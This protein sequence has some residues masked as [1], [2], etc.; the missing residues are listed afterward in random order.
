MALRLRSANNC[1]IGND[2]IIPLQVSSGSGYYQMASAN[3]A[4]NT[5]TVELK[6][7]QPYNKLKTMNLVSDARSSIVRH[8]DANNLQ[9]SEAFVNDNRISFEVSDLTRGVYH[10]IM[11]FGENKS[12]SETIILE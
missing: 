8:Y 4:K 1:G 11:T 2:V 3:P 5:I 7:D 12:F 9:R 6:G 10:L